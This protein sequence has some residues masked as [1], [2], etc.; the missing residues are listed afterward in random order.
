M[1]SFL[2][3]ATDPLDKNL[4][5]SRYIVLKFFWTFFVNTFK[6]LNFY[7]TKQLFV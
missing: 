7:V 2:E 4:G 1:K 3:E 5:E 6:T